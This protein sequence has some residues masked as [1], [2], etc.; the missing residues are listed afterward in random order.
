MGL[1]D[2]FIA[3]NVEKYI[4]GMIR[5]GNRD[6][7]FPNLVYDAARSYTKSNGG[8]CYS[9]TPGICSLDKEFNG[10]NYYI[11]F[12]KGRRATNIT[13]RKQ[14][15]AYDIVEEDANR[16]VKSS[17]ASDVLEAVLE[18]YN[19][20]PKVVRSNRIDQQSIQYFFELYATSIPNKVVDDEAGLTSFGL[21]AVPEVG[22]LVVLAAILNGEAII[23]AP[24]KIEVELSRENREALLAWQDESFEEFRSL[25]AS[26]ACND[27]KQTSRGS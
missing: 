4:L 26:E 8:S 17:Y 27:P 7:D 12:M 22:V 13:L 20:K 21:V 24:G 16:M 11:T 2:R 10:E 25:L 9:D 23:L 18:S 5:S 19:E 1:L 6:E 14:P 15:T 3:G